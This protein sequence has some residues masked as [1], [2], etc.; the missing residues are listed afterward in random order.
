MLPSSQPPLA[1]VF[2][3][4]QDEGSKSGPKSHAPSCKA[5]LRVCAYVCICE[6]VCSMPC[7]LGSLSYQL[8]LMPLL[9]AWG[10]A[11][12]SSHL[13]QGQ[14]AD[15]GPGSSPAPVKSACALRLL[16]HG[17]VAATSQ[18]PQMELQPH[19]LPRVTTGVMLRV[20]RQLVTLQTSL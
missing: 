4:P 13:T 2:G 17:A 16:H 6:V 11:C 15:A 14:L 7:W 18:C 3:N 5:V 9:R 12:S 19:T 20:P 1:L 8:P 10:G